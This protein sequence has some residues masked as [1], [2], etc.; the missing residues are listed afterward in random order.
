MTT[1]RVL[2]AKLFGDVGQGPGVEDHGP[3]GGGAALVLLEDMLRLAPRISRTASSAWYSLQGTRGIDVSP[4]SSFRRRAHQMQPDTIS[5]AGPEGLLSTMKCSTA[6]AVAMWASKAPRSACSVSADVVSPRQLPRLGRKR[7]AL[8][9]VE[10]A[11]GP[12]N[13]A[14][15]QAEGGRTQCNP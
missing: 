1:T 10:L 2:G 7:G 14:V 12:T 3:K 11:S 9:R 4:L 6:L 13:T 5:A 15:E 8:Q